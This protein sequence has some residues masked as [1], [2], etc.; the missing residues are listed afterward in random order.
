MTFEEELPEDK[1]ANLSNNANFVES[2]GNERADE[3]PE[4][5]SQ[6]VDGALPERDGR[7]DEESGSFQ[8]GFEASVRDAQENQGSL[9]E[10]EI[11]DNE[12]IQ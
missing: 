3:I 11:A 5:I 10:R 2:N 6:G 8:R 4:S 7:V 12:T 1:L 9:S